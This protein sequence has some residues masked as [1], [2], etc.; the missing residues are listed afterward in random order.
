MSGGPFLFI[1]A[2]WCL[3]GQG[4]GCSGPFSPWDGPGDTDTDPEDKKT[5]IYY[6]VLE[7]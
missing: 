1:G 4:R 2:F 6:S 7:E 3:G 5:C